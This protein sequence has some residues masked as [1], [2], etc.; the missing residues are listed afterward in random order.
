MTNRIAALTTEFWAKARQIE[1]FPR[2]LELAVLWALPL[3]IVKLPRLGIK[4]L[5]NWLITKGIPF[6][7]TAAECR[8]RACLLA[9]EGRGIVFIDGTD[10]EDQQRFS[11]AH[12]IAHFICDYLEPRKKLIALFGESVCSVLDGQRMPTAREKLEGIFHGI[13]IGS[14]THLLDRSQSGDIERFEILDSEDNADLLAL[15]LLAPRS[16]VISVLEDQ[17]IQ[18]RD[19]SAIEIA[20]EALMR[21]FGLP[22]PIAERYGYML[23]RTYRGARNFREWLD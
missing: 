5:R 3:A 4:D 18:W 10:S 12:E 9:R 23:M 13:E 16:I 22:K 8:L 6:D 15:E 17:R 19:P 7:Y 1:P 11:L 2:C 14:F 21:K 20:K